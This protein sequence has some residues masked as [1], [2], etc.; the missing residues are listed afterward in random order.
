MVKKSEHRPPLTG[1]DPSQ[2]IT[3]AA[4]AVVEIL[5]EKRRMGDGCCVQPW[6]TLC[7]MSVTQ[8]GTDKQQGHRFFSSNIYNS[9]LWVFGTVQQWPWLLRIAFRVA[10]PYKKLWIF[11]VY[12]VR[13]AVLCSG[14]WATGWLLHFVGNQWIL[15]HMFVVKYNL[16]M[17]ICNCPGPNCLE[18]KLSR[19]Q[20]PAFGGRQF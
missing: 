12:S 4:L 14:S 8:P 9:L 17:K 13:F 7:Q 19:V 20:L 11:A 2:T 3:R 10:I 18:F 5:L 6:P 16:I 1:R 15:L